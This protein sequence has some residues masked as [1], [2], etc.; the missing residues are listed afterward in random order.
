MSDK[1]ARIV[2]KAPWECSSDELFQFERLVKKGK[3]VEVSKLHDRIRYAYRL[4]FQF[5]GVSITGVAAMKN[6][7]PSYRVKIAER[8]GFALSVK[9]W[10]YELGWVY[11]EPLA[12]GAG[13]AS[14]LSINLLGDV[15]G[16]GV[17]STMRVSNTAMEKVL[18]RNGFLA[19]G[20]TYNSKRTGEQL[21]LWVRYAA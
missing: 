3:E 10:P 5:S 11:V 14:S 2:V 16:R 6:P 17:Y 13:V 19:V 9:S 12:R 18:R 1:P 4:A 20:R 15:D 7:E 8:S 21:R